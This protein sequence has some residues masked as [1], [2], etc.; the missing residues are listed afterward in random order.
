MLSNRVT[1]STGT[2]VTEVG[3]LETDVLGEIVQCSSFTVSSICNA[4]FPLS[5]E[6]YHLCNQNSL[7]FTSS[8][9][10]SRCFAVCEW[11]LQQT[12]SGDGCAPFSKLW[13]QGPL[14]QL[15]L[16]RLLDSSEWEHLNLALSVTGHMWPRSGMDG[17]H[18]KLVKQ[19]CSIGAL[20]STGIATFQGGA[21]RV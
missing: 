10:L 15:L 3:E 5:Q 13:Q 14:L 9:K 6:Y 1:F 20:L 8:Q 2:S 17:W 4:T 11:E 18:H 12:S 19:S 7:I 16:G 21:M